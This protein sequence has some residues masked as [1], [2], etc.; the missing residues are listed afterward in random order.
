MPT[1]IG[2]RLRS[3]RLAK[4]WTQKDLAERLNVTQGAVST[5]ERDRRA[6]DYE[7]LMTLAGLLN[8][9]A[10]A[11]LAAENGAPEADITIPSPRGWERLTPEDR[12]EVRH[13]VF[14]FAQTLVSDFRAR[15]VRRPRS[16]AGSETDA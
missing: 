7:T 13:L 3:L 1:T 15:R 9:P 5:W 8:V 11:L 10:S 2:R 16:R 4:G 12:D 6:P 14:L